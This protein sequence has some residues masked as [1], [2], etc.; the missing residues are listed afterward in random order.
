MNFPNIINTDC[1]PTAPP[2][3]DARCDDP[4]FAL[5]HPE[6]CSS[7][8]VLVLKPGAAIACFLGSI[9][10]EAFVE[11][12]GVET[13]V[14]SGVVFTTSDPTI[15][16]V[17]ANSGN[18]T[19]TGPGVAT[20][21][22]TYQGLTATAKLTILA[23]SNCCATNPVAT[24]LVVDVSKSMSLAF[25]GSY[26][27]KESFAKF[28]ASQY[29]SQLNTA[30]DSQGLVT[31]DT[32]ATLAVPLTNVVATVTAAINALTPTQNQTGI[33]LALQAAVNALAGSTAPFKVIVLFSDGEDKDTNPADDPTIIANQFKLAG[34]I[35]ICIGLRA[36]DA[37][38]AL[39]NSLATGGFFINAYP[40][41]DA[42]VPMEL[43]GLKGY[44]CAGSCGPQGDSFAYMPQLD[45]N[46][47]KNWN[48]T[49]HVDLFGPGL[50]DL[51]PGNGMYVNLVSNKPNF[52][53]G[54]TSKSSF[55][56]I[57][58]KTYRLSFYLAGNQRMD[59]PGYAVQVG[60][61]TALNQT[62]PM[63]NYLEPFTKYSF[64]FT[65]PVNV[66]APITFTQ[67]TGG[68]VSN[69][70]GS[71]LDNIL[72]ENVTDAT[73]IFSD[74]FDTENLTY[75]PP[76]CGPSITVPG[77]YGYGC[78]Y[79]YGC[80]S[81]PPGTQVQDPNPLPDIE[82]GFVP[83]TTYT[84]T[85][86][87]T[88]T[89]PSGTSQVGATSLV[90]VMTGFTTPSGIVTTSDSPILGFEGW[91]AFGTGPAWHG[92]GVPFGFNLDRLIYQFTTPQT[93]V[94]FAITPDTPMIGFAMNIQ[95]FGSNDGINY[96][97]LTVVIPVT[98]LTASRVLFNIGTPGSYLYYQLLVAEA[99]N[100]VGSIAVKLLEYLG[101]DPNQNGVTK[102][103]TATSTISQANADALALAAATA[104]AN[105]ALA[106]TGCIATFSSTQSFTANCPVGC[107]G[108]P[109]T[110]SATATSLISQ[111]DAD[112]KALAAAQTA[113]TAAL[114]CTFSNNGQ[115][116]TINDNAAA[117]PYP[118]VFYASGFTGVITK[119]RVHLNGLQHG[120]PSDI[121]MFLQSPGGKRVLIMQGC[122]NGFSVVAPGINI[123]FDDAAGSGLPNTLLTS[124]TF[125]PTVNGAQVVFPAPAPA[126]PYLTTLAGFN[127]DSPNGCWA[128]FCFDDKI[129][130]SGLISGGW[131]I[132]ITTA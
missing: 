32:S 57:P 128:L 11:L 120:F 85:K 56:F 48:A 60:I 8:P 35:I 89:C 30:K 70:F 90:P 61:G 28:L 9:Q 100:G 103:A 97:P 55:N 15:A 16:L 129:L 72:L 59:L 23:G 96:T 131:S 75:I 20:I 18:A 105:A 127:S 42:T 1:I 107:L 68:A 24:M 27:S 81:S 121:A 84:S 51:L 12:A 64:S 123:I 87:F 101:V 116:V 49:G 102:T 67:I 39:L 112:A 54:L 115:Q 76:K 92:G 6:I 125:K 83:P 114:V 110:K 99:V 77:Y 29:A 106:Q 22:A 40:G 37:G 25:D 71:L 113:A 58:G 2:P 104:A 126:G 82:A 122:G 130:D 63:P 44:I 4:A 7:S 46:G 109:V 31:F 41:L 21:T 79:G 108:P 94:E 53:G 66:T 34:G 69:V 50:F 86:S 62:I 74:N 124:G 93:V 10:F 36:H 5:L 19:G 33:G 45:Y 91:R 43:S 119:I 132:D 17:G 3:P 88:A 26:P 47:F 118:S 13:Q 78:N 38:Y 14:T 95:V 80:S 111:A 52:T 65:V 98:F 117:T 73:T